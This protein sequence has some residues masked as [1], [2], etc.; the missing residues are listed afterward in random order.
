MSC[1]QVSGKMLPGQ[2]TRTADDF[3]L[4]LEGILEAPRG[5]RQIN[6]PCGYQA[7]YKNGPSASQYPCGV[8]DDHGG[9]GRGCRTG[10]C[11][12][13]SC[14]ANGCSSGPAATSAASGAAAQSMLPATKG[15]DTAQ[16]PAADTVPNSLSTVT[17]G[18]PTV[19]PPLPAETN[20]E[21]P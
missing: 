1:D 3:E 18:K 4:F 9:L 10:S 20:G 21:K 5:Q 16:Q 15:G 7:A 12:T 17:P 6:F 2:E 19:L 11:G 13:G 14:G 8:V